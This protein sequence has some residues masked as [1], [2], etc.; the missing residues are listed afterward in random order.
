MGYNASFRTA[1]PMR[2][3]VVAAGYADGVDR[4]LSNGGTV[5]AAG[6]RVPIVGMVSM[7]VCLVDLSS[8]PEV[9]PGGYITLLGRE[10]AESIDG[11]EMAERCRTIPY[12]VLC[13][14]G[15]RVARVYT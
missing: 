13:G 9:G 11:M 8:V 2:V 15:K 14:I 6:R 1:R 10:G 7:D 3:G 12:E 5:L 4:R